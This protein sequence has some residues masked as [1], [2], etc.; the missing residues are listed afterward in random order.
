MPPKWPRKPTRRDPEYRKLDD[1]Y[2][3]GAHAMIYGV[4]CS[5]AEFFNLLWRA[6]WR[7]LPWLIGIWGSLVAVHGIWVLLI[8]RYDEDPKP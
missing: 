4:V 7:W 8:A 5:G 2:T 1:R 6:E 3:L